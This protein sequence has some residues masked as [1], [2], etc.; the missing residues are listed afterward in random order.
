VRSLN[1][2]QDIARLLHAAEA[3]SVDERRSGRYIDGS[4][5]KQ[6]GHGGLAQSGKRSFV[7][8]VQEAVADKGLKNLSETL[9]ARSFEDYH[10]TSIPALVQSKW[11]YT[12]A[13]AVR[14]SVLDHMKR[15][16]AR[17]SIS[18]QLRSWADEKVAKYSDVPHRTS[19]DRHEE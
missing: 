6:A 14:M 9:A 12:S 11:F 2:A 8:A 3:S 16:E 13:M 5:S 10:D 15:A 19:T 1:N 18:K 17:N 4:M 7:H